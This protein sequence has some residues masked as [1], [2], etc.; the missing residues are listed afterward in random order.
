MRVCECLHEFKFQLEVIKVGC[1]CSLLIWWWWHV[2]FRTRHKGSWWCRCMAIHSCCCGKGLCGQDK[3]TLRQPPV[4]WDR[5]YNGYWHWYEL[6]SAFSLRIL[7]KPVPVGAWKWG[8]AYS[9]MWCSERG[10]IDIEWDEAE[11][12][13]DQYFNW[14]S[15]WGTSNSHFISSWPTKEK[16]R[17]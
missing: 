6:M 5:C 14:S 7:S 17:M 13:W 16:K 3:G 1:T 11:W 10:E 2:Q 12:V 9:A 4:W 15:N 8:W